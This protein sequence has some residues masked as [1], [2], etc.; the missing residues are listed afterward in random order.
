[1]SEWLPIESAPKDGTHILL[2]N[3][4]WDDPLVGWWSINYREN[5]ECWNDWDGKIGRD[6]DVY[7]P[8]KDHTPTHWCPLPDVTP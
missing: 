4:L 1:M 8:S 2:F 3:K 7:E 6:S 5:E